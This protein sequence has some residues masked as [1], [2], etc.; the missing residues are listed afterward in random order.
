MIG[1]AGGQNVKE[2]GLCPLVWISSIWELNNIIERQSVGGGQDI[3]LGKEQ[4][5]YDFCYEIC[6]PIL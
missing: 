2:R 6:V 1:V 4:P 5:S 3:L